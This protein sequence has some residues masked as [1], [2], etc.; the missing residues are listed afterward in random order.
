MK[1]IVG[2][3]AVVLLIAGFPLLMGS[4]ALSQT[5][6]FVLKAGHD[7]PETGSYHAGFL[8]FAKIVS[9]RT[10][11][12]V[13]IE[14]FP[15]AQL[16]NEVK[17]LESVR[18]GTV[19]FATCGAANAS[20]VVPE[21][22]FFS[23]SYLFA[24]Q[25]HFDRAM[26]PQ[27]EIIKTLEKI[28]ADKKA[29]ARMVGLFT[30]G[31][32]SIVNKVK[33]IKTVEDLK[34]MKIRVMASPIEQKVWTALGAQPTSIPTPETYSALQTGVVQGAENAPI[35][36]LGW[37]FYEPAKYYSLTEHQFFMAPV[38]MSDRAYQKLPADLR[39]I[40]L[41]CIQ[42][43]SVYERQA[44]LQINEKALEQLKTLGCE[45]NSDVDKDSFINRLKGI[46]DE[47]A[48]Q[49]KVQNILDLIRKARK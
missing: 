34:G 29:G 44:D 14:V 31:K 33:P 19:D 26:A 25:D 5:P 22:G 27:G 2:M 38:F 37:K 40:V 41:K 24:G 47:T 11:G 7:N 43:A 28:V 49:L 17:L 36:I 48:K 30:I 16:G 1:K 15:S 21:L 12:K 18:L 6:A 23:V 3:I 35:I 20:T 8:H 45:I 13:K 39:A 4:N 32:R 42:D 9:E 10:G 46:Q